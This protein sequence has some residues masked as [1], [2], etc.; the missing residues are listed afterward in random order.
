MSLL[1][2]TI[3]IEDGIPQ[4]LHWHRERMERSSVELWNVRVT[5]P[6]I[7]IPEEYSKGIVKCNIVYNSHSSEISFSNYTKREIKTLKPVHCNDIDYH[8]KYHNREK[9]N[10]LLELKGDCDEIIIIKNGFVTDTSFS[11]IIFK[12]DGRW[13]TPS[14]PLLNGTCRQRLLKQ[15]IIE[16]QEIRLED[17]YLLKEWELINAMR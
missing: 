17:F 12:S 7:I 15:G 3:R 9:L 5:L 1:F 8:L 4:H 6:E 16:E 11:N 13:I 14:T 2:E 10:Q